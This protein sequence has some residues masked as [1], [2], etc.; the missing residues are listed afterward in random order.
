MQS[1]GRGGVIINVGWDQAETGM[2]GDSGE[3]FGAVK[4][5]VHGATKS[6]ARSL[7]PKVRVNAVAPGWIRTA[8]GES[9][10]PAWQQRAITEAPLGRWGQPEDV[11][12]AVAWLAGPDA[13]FITGQIIRV[14]GGAVR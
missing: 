9:A 5:A 14:N 11:A 3:L 13:S 8:W 6:L 2:E 12:G 10:P 7:A 1:G 4:A